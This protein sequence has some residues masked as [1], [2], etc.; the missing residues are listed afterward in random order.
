MF[1]AQQQG[2]GVRVTGVTNSA[3]RGS[4]VVPGLIGCGEDSVLL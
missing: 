4:Q 2:L 3:Y 1:E